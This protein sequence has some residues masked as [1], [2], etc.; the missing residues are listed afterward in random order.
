MR[1]AVMRDHKLVVDEVKTPEPGPGQVL[2]KTLAC[3]IC[4]SDL[5]TLKYA[6]HV[7]EASRRTGGFFHWD[8]NRDVVLGHEFCAEIVDHG[9]HTNKS[10]KAG[11]RVCSIPVVLKADGVENIGFS[12]DSPGGYGEFMRLSEALLL[13]V[14]NGLPSEQA[15][16][17]EPLAVGLHAVEKARLDKNDVPLVIGCGPVGLAVIACLRLKGARPI[18]A[19]DFSPLRREFAL[20]MGADVVVNPAEKSPYTSWQ[21]VAAYSDP[22][23]APPLPPW[24][25]GPSLRPAVIFECVGVQGVIEQIMTGAP[26][27]AKIVVVG[28]CMGKDSIEPMFGIGKELNVQFVLAYTP[29]EYAAM[30]GHVAEG[31]IPSQLLITRKIGI[32]GVANAFEELANPEKQVKIV[33]EP[34]R[35]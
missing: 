12:N 23:Q 22:S 1:A 35:A 33:V 7:V 11:T 13:P 9:P 5:H 14:P 29:E 32:D 24:V 4:G 21:Q 18:V 25:P 15:A 31:R 2:V 20:R 17:V 6:E 26:Q 30:L 10:L 3:G 34:W 28:V 16:L 8:V 19:A 27:G